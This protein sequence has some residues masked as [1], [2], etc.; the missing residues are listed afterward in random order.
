MINNQT[1]EHLKVSCKESTYLIDMSHISHMHA[2][3]NY[4][5]IYYDQSYV[6]VSKTLSYFHDQLRED[7]FIRPHRSY[8]VNIDHII[9]I[10]YSNREL[11]LR[12]GEVIPISRSRRKMIKEFF[13]SKILI[14][15][16]KVNT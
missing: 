16:R 6:L 10:D 11:T 9:N 13:H 7:K 14:E 5:F 8:Y 12:S 3:S 15:T 2:S 1:P 4:S